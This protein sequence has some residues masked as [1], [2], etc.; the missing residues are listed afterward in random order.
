MKKILLTL[1]LVPFAGF[2]Q[3]FQWLKT[4][5]VSMPYNADMVGYPNTVDPQGNVYVAGYKD[6]HYVYNSIMGDVSL[7]KYA[8]DGFEFYNQTLTGKVQV[9]RLCADG[10]GNVYAAIS[11][12]NTL[13]VGELVFETNFQSEVYLLLKFDQNGNP[14]WYKHFT[15]FDYGDGFYNEI[16]ELR[17][18]TMD[19]TGKLYLG[20]A[21]FMQ[22][23]IEEINP[24]NGTTIRSINQGDVRRVTS[25]ATDNQGNLYATGSCAGNSARYNNTPAGTSLQ[26]NDYIVKYAPDFSFQ[27]VKYIEDITCSTPEVAAKSEDEIYFAGTQFSA[28]S[29]DNITTEGPLYGMDDF[30]LAKLNHN[31]E[32]QWVREVSGGGAFILGNRNF[33][34]VDPIGNVYLSGR[35]RFDINWGN[36]FTSGTGAY[37]YDATLVKY[38]SE[39]NTQMV[40]T[41]PSQIMSR[42]DGVAVA[43]SND[44]YCSGMGFGFISIDTISYD[45]GQISAA[46]PFVTKLEQ[47]I[48][49]NTNP[50]AKMPVLYPNPATNTLY[51]KGITQNTSAEIYNMLGQQV[52]VVAINP[53]QPLNISALQTGSY[54][55]K[56]DNSNP[57]KFIKLD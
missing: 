31:G 11:Y 43:N 14:L 45:P 47:T 53:G 49:G 51:L 44:V 34:A 12:L 20:Y 39:G 27:W 7:T 25:L 5:A 42:F 32:Y 56:L 10:N 29:F 26:Y 2:A 18:M 13:S 24:E 50:K 46:Y 35:S 4:P 41:A 38:D 6:N 22:S 54:V 15:P 52:L 48:A 28:T 9:H 37:T 16:T 40:K 3:Q 8:P 33:L 23:I 21:D 55:L 17:A 36:G 57:I 19:N 30:F 1:L